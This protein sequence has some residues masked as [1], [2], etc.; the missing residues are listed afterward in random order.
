MT[1]E[2]LIGLAIAV[3]VVVVLWRIVRRFPVLLLAGLIAVA[4]ATGLGDSFLTWIG[5]LL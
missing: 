4:V 2:T 1:V 5:G 3:V